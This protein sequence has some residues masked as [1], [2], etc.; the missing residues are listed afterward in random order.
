M[1]MQTLKQALSSNTYPGRGIVLGRTKD[2]KRAVA[3]YFIMGRS[4]NSR[5]RIFVPHGK[6]IRTEAFDPARM[7]DPSL[8][9]YAPVRAY[10]R[11]LIVTNGD[12]TDTV[13]D[14]LEQADDCGELNDASAQITFFQALATREFEPDAP[15]YTPRVSGLLTVGDGMRY[16]LSILKSADGDPSQCL[17]F[18]FDY[19]A[20]TAGVGHFIHTYSGDGSPLPSFVGEPEAVTLENDIDDITNEAWSALNADNKVSLFVR[21]I[22]LETGACD[23][24]I[25]NKHA[26]GV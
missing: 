23:T 19:E 16:T 12:Q 5:N 7:V 21:A 20:P 17:R 10:D 9:I 18:T 4:E 15:N 8:V 13:Y 3:M 24:R 1:N 2:G 22:D 11:Y 6:G 26:E 14:A 25:K